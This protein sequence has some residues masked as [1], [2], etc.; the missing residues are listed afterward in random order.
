M[1]VS[2][3]WRYPVKSMV[4]GRT[5]SVELDEL[6]IVG[7][8]TWAVRDLER[9]GIRGAKKIGSLMRLAASDVDDGQVEITLPD[10]STVRTTDPDVDARVSSALDHRV[11][12]ER[13]R[14]ADDLDHYRRGAPDS[15][16]VVA[17]LRGIFGRDEN[18]PFPDFSIFPPSIAEFE[19]PPGTYYDAFP[20]MVM[21]EAAL[22]ALAMALPDSSVD[23]R[24][25]RP[26]FVVDTEGDAADLAMPGHPEFD[27]SGR[28]ATVG[29]ATVE[30]GAPCPRC[31]MVTH[32]ISDEVPADRAVLR[33]IVRD[34]DQNLGIYATVVTPGV[35]R[36]G[37]AMT[38]V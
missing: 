23:I 34:L 30:F 24:R 29:T 19:S 35:V 1:H 31:V 25:F 9:G 26:S 20:L 11:R 14:P 13:L 27:W 7:D 18:E 38:F 22:A 10:G 4:G 12:L 32:E 15:D 5:E 36:A 33:H 17:E 28:R 2:Q 8:R 3:L 6:G 37:D 21:T 16:D